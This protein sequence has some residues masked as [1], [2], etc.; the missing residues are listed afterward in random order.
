MFN[1]KDNV[2]EIYHKLYETDELWE[3]INDEITFEEL[4]DRMQKGEDFYELIGEGDS[5]IRERI[6]NI[7]LNILQNM[8]YDIEY[9]DIYYLWLNGTTLKLNKKEK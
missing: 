4:L 8:D 6:F 3:E 9:D 7:L 2:K 5:I 1:L